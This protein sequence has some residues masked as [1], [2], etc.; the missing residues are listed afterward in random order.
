MTGEWAADATRATADG[1]DGKRSDGEGSRAEAGGR[2]DGRVK[3][4]V[5][6]S[7]DVFVS[8]QEIPWSSRRDKSEEEERESRRQTLGRV[9]TDRHGH[10]SVVQLDCRAMR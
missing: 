9:G 8:T 1:E 2:G 3:G 7:C 4:R 6:G 5:L 10:D